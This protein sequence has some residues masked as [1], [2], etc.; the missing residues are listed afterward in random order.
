MSQ[1]ADDA[2]EGWG[3]WL[4]LILGTSI[5]LSV[6]PW[7]VFTA[8]LVHMAGPDW[9]V[10]AGLSGPWALLGVEVIWFVAG[11]QVAA[12]MASVAALSVLGYAAVRLGARI[13]EQR[14]AHRLAERYDAVVGDGDAL[15]SDAWRDV[16]VDPAEPEEEEAR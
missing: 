9:W 6:P 15:R 3:G 4:R 2:R 14:A 11:V 13:V 16:E 12:A 1:E 8:L 5:A 10:E 7:F